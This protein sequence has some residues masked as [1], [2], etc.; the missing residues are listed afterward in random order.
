MYEMYYVMYY[1]CPVFLVLQLE[2]LHCATQPPQQIE[3]I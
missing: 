3:S 1:V 2:L